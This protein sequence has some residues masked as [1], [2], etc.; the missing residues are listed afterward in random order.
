M[1][2]RPTPEEELRQS[3]Q[4]ILM[5]ELV[6]DDEGQALPA[7]FVDDG[8]DAEFPTIV[9]ASLNEIVRPDMARIPRPEP[10]AG[11][12]IEPQPATSAHRT[13]IIY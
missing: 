1:S 12:V 2:G 5:V 4:H 9:G 3:R 6:S 7:E 13:S 11:S 8:E 10:D